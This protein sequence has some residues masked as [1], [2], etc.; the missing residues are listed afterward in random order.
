MFT[1]YVL[2]LDADSASNATS[3][4]LEI[5]IPF[6]SVGNLPVCAHNVKFSNAVFKSVA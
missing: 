3:K 1:Q 2:Q 5:R 6:I 4:L